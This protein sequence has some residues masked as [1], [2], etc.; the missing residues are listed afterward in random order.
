MKLRDDKRRLFFKVLKNNDEGRSRCRKSHLNSADPKE[1]LENLPLALRPRKSAGSFRPALLVAFVVAPP[2][3]L[4]TFLVAGIC[5]RN[6]PKVL[7]YRSNAPKRRSEIKQIFIVVFLIQPAKICKA[8][9]NELLPYHKTYLKIPSFKA[10]PIQCLSTK[11]GLH[12]PVMPFPSPGLAALPRHVLLE[13]CSPG[14][15]VLLA[16]QPF[17]ANGV[18]EAGAAFPHWRR[19][20]S[21]LVVPY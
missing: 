12:G 13:R 19:L 15:W 6:I 8:S 14:L 16:P 9:Q 7:E 18:G 4:S 5:K 10:F 17:L 1:K 3:E 11:H 20:G 21:Q 2:K